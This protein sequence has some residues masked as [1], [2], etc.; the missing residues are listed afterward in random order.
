MFHVQLSAAPLHLL[1]LQRSENIHLFRLDPCK[2]YHC[3]TVSLSDS[4]VVALAPVYA[5]KNF[6]VKFFLLKSKVSE[7]NNCVKKQFSI[8]LRKLS[9]EIY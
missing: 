7:I 8:E 2:C 4:T 9:L 3:R 6:R 5:S 1:S